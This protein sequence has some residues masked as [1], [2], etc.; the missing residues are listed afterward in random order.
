MESDLKP[1]LR[2]A[3]STSLIVLAVAIWA[4]LSE[5]TARSFAGRRRRV[6]TAARP[7]IPAFNALGQRAHN[8]DV[9][10][11]PAAARF[12]EVEGRGLL[13]KVWINNSGPYSFAI[14]TGAGATIISKR[15]ASESR[16]ALAGA[17][18]VSLSGLSGLSQAEGREAS[19]NRLDDRCAHTSGTRRPA[20]FRD[21][22]RSRQSSDSF[23]TGSE[24]ER[25][26][27]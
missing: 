7:N 10:T 11:L 8:L 15:V 25:S 14:D 24:V 4:V 17:N 21:Q 5:R 12:R 1:M 13:V 20:S 27:M 22:F 18:H 6:A 19:F 2:R 26:L 9:P 16:V 3:T 23:A